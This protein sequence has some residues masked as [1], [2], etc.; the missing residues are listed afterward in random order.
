MNELIKIPDVI[1]IEVEEVKLSIPK[2]TYIG[3]SATFL[4]TAT[5][6]LLIKKI[7]QKA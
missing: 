2:E 4:A 6:F 3:A 5:L 7:V 1:K